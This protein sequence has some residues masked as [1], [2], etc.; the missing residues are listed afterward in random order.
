MD[1]FWPGWALFTLVSALYCAEILSQ[2]P[3]LAKYLR[4]LPPER[5]AALP[6]H[7]N[8]PRW[9]VFGSTRFFLVVF[10][11]ALRAVPGDGHELLLIKRRMRMSAL[12]ELVG[13][14][15]TLGTWAFLRT[16]GWKPWP[17]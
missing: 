8:D 17:F 13:A 7:P 16:H 14:A 4:A 10:R 3:L 6:R 9:A 12:R 2:L 15:A 11:D 1:P 5:R